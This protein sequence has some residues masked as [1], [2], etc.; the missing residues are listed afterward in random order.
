MET[1]IGGLL[2]I[3]LVFVLPAILIEDRRRKKYGNKK[4]QCDRC[5]GEKWPCDISHVEDPG[6]VIGRPVGEYVRVC[7]A[8]VTRYDY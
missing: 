1:L 7:K 6:E 4:V 8:C 3:F 2:V 5:G